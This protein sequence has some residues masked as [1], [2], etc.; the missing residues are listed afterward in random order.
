MSSKAKSS[1]K[2]KYETNN[3]DKAATPALLNEDDLLQEGLKAK[4][5]KDYDKAIECFDKRYNLMLS[6]QKYNLET[7]KSL[8]LL[9]DTQ[10]EG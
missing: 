8:K 10:V 9:G 6:H 5:D 7:Q 4:N 3:H 1:S 2:A